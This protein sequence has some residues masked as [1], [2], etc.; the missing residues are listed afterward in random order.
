MST[1]DWFVEFYGRN[2]RE[3][4]LTA[5]ALLEDAAAAEEVTREAFALAHER[6]AR[7]E[8]AESPQE[9]V[10]TVVVRLARR[11]LRWRAS[12]TMLD[13]LRRREPSAGRDRATVRRLHDLAGLSADTIASIVD[14][15][16]ATVEAHLADAGPVSWASVR[17]PSVTRVLERSR[18]RGTRRRMLAGAAVA[19]LVLAV[20]V[21]L[22]R[23]EEDPTRSAPVLPSTPTGPA[24]LESNDMIYGVVFADARHGY[25]MHATTCEQET[26][27]MELLAT[28]D[29]E[30]WS[31]RS[32]P[33]AGA[34]PKAV[35]VVTALGPDE[36]AV[37]W[38]MREDTQPVARVHSTDGGRTWERVSAA[39]RGS[40]RE[41]PP[42]ATLR[43]RCLRPVQRCRGSQVVVVRP[44][45][46]ESA[47]LAG[48]PRLLSPFP[49]DV[50][51]GGEYWWVAGLDP[52]TRRPVVA[53]SRDGRTWTTARLP[54]RGETED[55]MWSV[56]ANGDTL[57]AAVRGE[58]GDSEYGLLAIFRSTDGGRSWTRTGGRMPDTSAGQLVAAAD[59]TLVVTTGSGATLVSRDGGR[60]FTR[61]DQRLDGYVYWTRAG[62]VT[63]VI[64]GGPI[65]FSADGVHWRELALRP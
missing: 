29:G 44:G 21:P 10:R 5:H 27:A 40:V 31:S 1:A 49:G 43:P 41:I 24:P 22:L 53:L 20:A 65:L 60:T 3:L 57:Y 16:V 63:S 58:Q 28:D 12:R 55:Q 15:P 9:W 6:R 13:H 30:H 19:V 61:S 25:A 14:I 8:R 54:W 42:G 35:G 7:L 50:P 52:G 34:P 62:Y 4:L 64:P 2:H 23:V 37:D 11:R 47:W 45:T 46:G 18:Q 36:V 59:G 32:V 39:V 33:R 38:L 51:A 26:C 17:Q 48:L 56:V